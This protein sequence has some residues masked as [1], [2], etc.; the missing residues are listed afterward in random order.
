MRILVVCGA[1]ASS[2]F[3]A[4]R[5]T[6]AAANAG[7]A[8]TAEAGT[9]HTAR[10][11]VGVDLILVGPHIAAHADELTALQGAPVIPLPP[12]TF[13]DF[14]GSKTLHFVREAMTASHNRKE[15]P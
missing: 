15:T 1:G 10:T 14:D 5:L 3:V 9:E 11:A 4:Q 2:T 8:W 12:D 7:L 13:S 6:R